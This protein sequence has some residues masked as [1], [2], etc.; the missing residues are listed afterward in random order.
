[1]GGVADW[2]DIV[3]KV[4]SNRGGGHSPYGYWDSYV[5]TMKQRVHNHCEG[6]KHYRG[7]S[8]LFVQINKS[9]FSLATTQNKAPIITTPSTIVEVASLKDIIP[10]TSPVAADIA[11]PPQRTLTEI[12]RIL[13]DTKLSREVK[14][15]HGFRCQ[16]CQQ[17]ALKLD[18]DRFYAEVHHIRPLGSPHFGPD[19]QENV[20]CVC[21]NCHV[22]LDYGA[23]QLDLNQLENPKGHMVA[24]E[25]IN[26]HNQ[27]IYGKG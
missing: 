6:F 22:R 10:N 13:R 24:I 19:V 1:L 14:K 25:Y 3:S 4:T 26:Y 20:L 17:P 12:Y 23:I 2:K 11:E 8:I 7:G 16:V 9:R 21:P 27:Q 18:D 15:L 5:K